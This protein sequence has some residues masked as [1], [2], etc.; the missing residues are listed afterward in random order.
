MNRRRRTQFARPAVSA[1]GVCLAMAG[2]AAQETP[3]TRRLTAWNAEFTRGIV[4]LAPGVYTAV[5]YGG[6]N[7]SMLVGNDGVVMI[8]TGSAAAETAQ[9]LDALRKRSPLPVKA[10]IYTHGHA[11]HT[12]GSSLF[13]DPNQP[14]PE[15]WARTGFGGELGTLE[16]AGLT[17]N[18]VRGARQ[19]GQRLPPEKRINNGISPVT[20][21]ARQGIPVPA[22]RQVPAMPPNRFFDERTTLDV[23]GIR[24]ELVANPGETEDHL[25]VWLP[26]KKVVFAGDNFY[27][28]MP[29]LYAIRGT[30]YRDVRQWA[31]ALD[32]LLSKD[33][34]HL[35][36]G[37]TRPI[38]G[39]E[40][41]KQALTDYRDTIR[42]IFDKT[43]EG[44]NQ[45]LTPDEL[46]DFV[47]LPPRLA[48]KEYLQ[49][50]YGHPHW[51]VR[52]I[53]AGHLGWF[54]GSPTNLFPLT[55]RAEAERMAKLARGPDRL[56]KALDEAFASEDYQWALQL[57][58]Y[59]LLLNSTGV[60]VKKL[61]AAALEKLAERT[62][63]APA[64]N[65]YFSV[66]QEIRET[67]GSR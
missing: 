56:R 13:V 48:E 17:I 30:P 25:Y 51:A 65:Y 6:S 11:D 20:S 47:Q 31:D 3:A 26:D 52:S 59:L 55:P 63:S 64:R 43:I 54:D 40:A 60:E 44:M 5:G 46:V 58:D 57:S 53:F 1:L 28:C 62:V 33:A 42:F 7:L 67:I 50:Y 37:H 34:E 23:A 16:T 8:D 27:R 39:S 41:V 24:L 14:P 29:N 10:I 18:R 49:P 9:A 35:V 32:R 4:E 2:V 22:P 21:S 66:A 15:I 61:K 19:F 45:G 38:T 12:A 36:P